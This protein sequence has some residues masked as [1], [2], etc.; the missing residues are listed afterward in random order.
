MRQ[1]RPAILSRSWYKQAKAHLT[2]EIAMEKNRKTAI[3]NAEID[4]MTN[5]ELLQLAK[6]RD[7]KIVE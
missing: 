4:T 7:R 5:E 1:W 3:T 6:T 2:G